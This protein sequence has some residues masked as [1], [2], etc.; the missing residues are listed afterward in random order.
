VRAAERRFAE[1]AEVSAALTQ[2]VFGA[3]GASSGSQLKSQ[4]GGSRRAILP[5]LRTQ[6]AQAH[7]AY[8]AVLD[9]RGHLVAGVGALPRHFAVGE[10]LHGGPALSDVQGSAAG[11]VIEFAPLFTG[12][13]GPRLLVEGLPVRMMRAF[14]TDYLA[15]LPNPD[16]AALTM[17]DGAG[18]PLAH[19][20]A[21]LA[22]SA[23]TEQISTSALVPGT[24]WRL[25][26]IAD[27][28]RVVVGLARMPWL[29]WSML[30]ALAVALLAGAS[31]LPAETGRPAGPAQRR[32]QDHVGDRRGRPLR[33]GAGV[34]DA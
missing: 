5:R 25:R 2:S 34:D 9:H 10:A 20:K 33:A 30:L 7:V 24:R 28:N 19:G 12:N 11:K 26:L 8:M 27:R 32:R 29:A 13:D 31:R 3:L 16:G 1:R 23:D 22:R 14:L 4:F 15:R 21:N 18:M 6:F 17:V